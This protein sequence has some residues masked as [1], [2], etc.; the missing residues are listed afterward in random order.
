RCATEPAARERPAARCRK[1]LRWGSF[2]A[3]ASREA[4]CKHRTLPQ[5]ARHGHVAAH[6]AR[7]LARK[8]KAEPGAAEALSARG[9][10]L[11]KLLEQLG[12]L[13]RCHAG[14]TRNGVYRELRSA[15][16]ASDRPGRV[17]SD[18]AARILHRAN[19]RN[20]L[21]T[22]SSEAVV[23]TATVRRHNS[24]YRD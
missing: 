23:M 12:L 15:T 9:I 3:L 22:N 20:R 16:S 10:G 24:D 4:N 8:G 21:A 19:R 7:E 6:H 17:A 1:S 11:G 2:M 18:R 13:L 5:L 14:S